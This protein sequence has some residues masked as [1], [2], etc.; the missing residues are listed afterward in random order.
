MAYTIDTKSGLY[1]LANSIRKVN[2]QTPVTTN[3]VVATKTPLPAPSVAGETAGAAA[4]QQA[5]VNSYAQVLKSQAATGAAAPSVAGETAGAA[6]Q[7][8]RTAAAT[9]AQPAT[10]ATP[11][12]ETK[13]SYIDNNGNKQIGYADVGTPAAPTVTAEDTVVA[14]DA[15]TVEQTKEELDYWSTMKEMY[16]NLYAEAVKA[17]DAQAAI[18]AERAAAAAEE[19]IAALGAQ[20]ESTNRQLYRDYM[21]TQKALP[22]QLA[23]QGYTGGMS[24]SA[25][26]RLGMSYEEALAQNER[27]RI[28]AASGIN[29]ERAQTE[30]EIQA[31]A[32]EANRAALENQNA[33]LIA[34][35]QEQYAYEQALKEARAEQMAAAGDFSGML[36]LGYTQDEVDYLTRLWL[37]ENPDAKSTWI[38]AHPEDA[39]RLGITKE[40]KKTT[41]VYTPTQTSTYAE[42]LEAQAQANTALRAGATYEEVA[43]ELTDMAAKG[44]ISTTTANGVIQSMSNPTAGLTTTELNAMKRAGK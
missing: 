12:T 40:K 41:A 10:T 34:L 21:Q 30:Y 26:L 32:A 33:Q 6:I 7:A 8:S 4:E 27:A 16:A 13:V 19:Q 37:L 42:M 11:T 29:S 5:K 9:A 15:A 18:A 36:D 22:Q 35:Q 20:Y 43:K 3:Q 31:A 24:E 44:E 23:A 14:E 28:A 2:N 17:N 38:E 25:R 1:K 39:K